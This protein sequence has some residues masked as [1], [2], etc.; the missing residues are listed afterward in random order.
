MAK[1]MN[2]RV[3]VFRSHEKPNYMPLVRHITRSAIEQ[4]SNAEYEKQFRA[5]MRAKGK[6]PLKSDCILSRIPDEVLEDQEAYHKMVCEIIAL[7]GGN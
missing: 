1:E 4:F 2:M 6:D 3:E 7:Q 5:W